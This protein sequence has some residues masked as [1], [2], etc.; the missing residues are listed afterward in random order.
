MGAIDTAFVR[1]FGSTVDFL[2]QQKGTRLRATIRE[3]QR[4]K[5]EFAFFDQV[6]ATAAQ[7]TTTRNADSPLIKTDHQ[8]RRVGMINVEWGDLIDDFDR[9][10][11]L[12]DP[13]N[14]TTQNAGFAIGREMDDIILES[15]F[16]DAASGKEGNTTVSFPSSQQIA[17]NFGSGGNTGLT[18]AKLRE[19][20]RKLLAANV[21]MMA[22]GPFTIVVNSFSLDDLL[23]TTEVTSSDFNTVRAL[24]SG[25]IDTFLGFKF[26][27]SER[28]LHE[29]ATPT[30]ARIPVYA[31]NGVGLALGMEPT[32]RIA[33]RADKR[34]S[35]YVY[36]STVVGAVRLEEVKVVEIKVDE[37]V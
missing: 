29:T 27:H 28:V 25:E 19:A 14:P 10:R 34:F 4:V 33:E 36:W 8:R 13:T 2:A 6:A 32:A 20:R 22:D 7:R 30:I 26:V 37:A 17:V 21:D 1:Q 18:I 12:I 35:T 31:A 16:G 5:A 11:M 23:A 9:V 24:V 15:L 3:Q